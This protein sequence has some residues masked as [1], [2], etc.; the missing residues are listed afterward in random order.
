ME[1]IL[2]TAGLKFKDIIK[3]QDIK[4]YPL[5][6]TFITGKSG[7]GKSTL[8]KLFNASLTPSAGHI[9]YKQTDI[10]QTDTLEL[11]K[12]ISLVNQS[13]FLFDKTIRGNFH[14]FY[15]YREETPPADETIKN[16]LQ[17]CRADF[18][19]SK[20]CSSMSGGEKHRA[21]IAI[22]L[23]FLPEILMLD[24]PTAA[25]DRE[26]GAALLENII[27]FS[28]NSGKTLII[29]SH[30]DTLTQNYAENIINLENG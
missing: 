4:I 30:D 17:I 27:S 23:S 29:V 24:E 18:P 28:Q 12:N 5:Q 19:L 26:N 13:V 11:R 7:A 14:D 9:Y 1:P 2:E 8:L 6:P 20:D 15:Y 3:Y 21:F 22:Y 25:L 10:S 16:F